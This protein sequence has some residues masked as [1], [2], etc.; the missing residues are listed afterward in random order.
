MG[1]KRSGAFWAFWRLMHQLLDEGRRPP[2]IVL[3]NVVGLLRPAEFSGLA[4]ALA[5]LGM[6]FGAMVVDAVRFLPQSR[7]RVF[8]VAV[9]SRIDPSPWV[10]PDPQAWW[11]SKALLRTYEGLSDEMKQQWLWWRLPPPPDDGSKPALHELIDAD[12]PDAQWHT[13]AETAYLIS[14]MNDLHRRRLAES[15]ASGIPVGTLYRRT[16]K[17][18]QRAE[19]RFDGIAGCLRT[20]QGGSSRQT[21]VEL[22]SGVVRTRLVTARETA[23][24][25]G[26]PDRLPLPAHY[27]KAYKAMGDGVAVPTVTHLGDHLLT[28]LADS[29]ASGDALIKAEFSGPQ[30][31][32][33]A[34][35]AAAWAEMMSHDPSSGPN[36]R[37]S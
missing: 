21:V 32:R 9:D 4:E 22:R 34:K 15:L 7:P 37:S 27:N 10:S 17:G 18:V 23:R 24:L 6:R 12:P 5:D 20:P 28:P 8:V 25:M 13:E 11:S 33:S 26:V 14:L 36:Q 19:V 30:G 35:R 3:E 1:S 31:S 29:I 16:R 2:I